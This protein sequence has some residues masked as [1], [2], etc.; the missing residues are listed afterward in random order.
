[1]KK[2]IL[3][4][5][6]LYSV[7]LSATT[8]DFDLKVAHKC[9]SKVREIITSP[10]FHFRDSKTPRHFYGKLKGEEGLYFEDLKG[11]FLFAANS[12]FNKPRSVMLSKHEAYLIKKKNGKL[13]IQKTNGKV[14]GV[15]PIIIYP[16]NNDSDFHKA[17][18]ILILRYA[19]EI[20]SSLKK[21][22]R[23][24]KKHSQLN[25]DGLKEYKVLKVCE[26]AAKKLSLSKLQTSLQLEIQNIP[27]FSEIQLQSE[28]SPKK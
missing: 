28:K 7:S 6:F 5:F 26:L 17:Y 4:S 27:R 23:Y 1:M 15:E 20:I 9:L 3:A 14:K 21:K 24:Q 18:S 8:K 16:S 19:K 12:R 11:N 10:D 22:E 2:L 25:P 13:N